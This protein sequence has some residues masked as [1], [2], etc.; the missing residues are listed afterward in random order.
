MKEDRALIPGEPFYYYTNA[1]AIM[2]D[3]DGL[4]FKSA[5]AAYNYFVNER[6]YLHQPVNVFE[7]IVSKSSLLSRLYSVRFRIG[8]KLEQEQV[9]RD[10]NISKKYLKQIKAIAQQ[11]QVPVKFV[12]IPEVKEADLSIEECKQKYNDLL[13]DGDL[14]TDWLVLQ[15]SK[16]YFNDYPDGH[17][18][19][20]GH[21]HYADYLKSVFDNYFGKK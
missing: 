18:N 5:Q 19:N 17:L 16:A 8:E 15:N 9:I 14:K 2:A 6:Y 7:K 21:R 4:H 1:G 3:V 11:N 13:S 20:A 10:S 12:L